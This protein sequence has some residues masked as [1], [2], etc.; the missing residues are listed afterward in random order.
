MGTKTELTPEIEA[1][2]LRGLEKVWDRICYDCLHLM[3][4]NSMEADEVREI[5]VDY[6][7]GTVRRLFYALSDEDQGKVLCKAF[8]YDQCI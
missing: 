8:P 2:L 3:P 7:E 1:E 5:V 6:L 4:N